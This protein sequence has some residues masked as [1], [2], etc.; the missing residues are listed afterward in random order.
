MQLIRIKVGK[1]S[2]AALEDPMVLMG[3]EKHQRLSRKGY[4]CPLSAIRYGRKEGGGCQFNSFFN[5]PL[6]LG[7]GAC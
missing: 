2:R 7:I 1:G 4:S 3:L 5:Y 6:S